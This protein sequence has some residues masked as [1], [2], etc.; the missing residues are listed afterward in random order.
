MAAR[1]WGLPWPRSEG[2]RTLASAH[3]RS[4]KD[5]LPLDADSAKDLMAK[6]Q[7]AENVSCF[8]LWLIMIAEPYG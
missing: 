6:Q 3:S 1:A 5:Q 7:L 2:E 4:K 8:G